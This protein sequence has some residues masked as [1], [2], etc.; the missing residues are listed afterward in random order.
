MVERTRSCLDHV[1]DVLKVPGSRSQQ[2]GCPNP[3]PFNGADWPRLRLKPP[4]VSYLVLVIARWLSL[5]KHSGNLLRLVG[6]TNSQD[7][8]TCEEPQAPLGLMWRVGSNVVEKP[9]ANPCNPCKGSGKAGVLNVLCGT[10]P[11]L[12]D[13]PGDGKIPSSRMERRKTS[14]DTRGGFPDKADAAPRDEP[15]RKTDV[16]QENK[17]T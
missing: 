3:L 8:C 17:D 12:S 13:L 11:E 6:N 2:W 7:P 14:P 16:F 1:W 9:W 5:G 10:F 4:E 15:R